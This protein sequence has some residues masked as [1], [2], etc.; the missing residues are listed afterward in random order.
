MILFNTCRKVRMQLGVNFIN[1][2]WAAFELVEL[3]QSY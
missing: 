2:Q 3:G 1:I